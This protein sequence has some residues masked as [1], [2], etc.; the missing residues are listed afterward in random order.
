MLLKKEK[1]KSSL[2]ILVQISHETNRKLVEIPNDSCLQPTCCLL[3]VESFSIV[4]TCLIFPLN[5]QATQ[6]WQTAFHKKIPF[7]LFNKISLDTR[8]YFL[9]L[10]SR[11]LSS[12]LRF[13]LPFC[14]AF[15]LDFVVSIIF[16]VVP[17]L[18]VRNQR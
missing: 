8:S 15:L 13:V 16:S 2:L 4:N 14:F 5:Q 6:N 7:Y 17:P 3:E 10:F 11:F 12:L 9:S 18:N 1:R